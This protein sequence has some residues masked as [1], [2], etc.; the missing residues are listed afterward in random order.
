M[1]TSNMPSQSPRVGDHV[2]VPW[3]LDTLDGVVED[4]YETGAGPRVV[5][6]ILDPDAS[7]ETETV[8]L[9][10]EVV[11]LA[12]EGEGSPP[13]SWLTGA[14]YQRNVGKAL[15]RL[16]PTLLG[17]HDFHAHAWAQPWIDPDRRPD[18]LI[19]AGP[20]SLVVEAK[21]GGAEKHVTAET[22]QQLQAFLATLPRDVSA[23]LVIDAELTPQARAL[24]YET[25]RLR[26]VRWRNARDDS[27]LGAAVA[28]LLRGN[29]GEKQED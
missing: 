3:G 2:R 11:E 29:V 25:P 22:V 7:G 6:R 18:F 16:L 20:R 9:P 8:A 15:Q 27:R 21:T 1:V 5:I 17:E 23:L 13:G 28:S 4:V 10:A 14:R 26:A 19:H 24:L 12:T